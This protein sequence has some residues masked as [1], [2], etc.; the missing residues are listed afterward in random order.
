MNEGAAGRIDNTRR[1]GHYGFWDPFKAWRS[2][3]WTRWKDRIHG[4]DV[5]GADRR[6][7]TNGGSC[8]IERRG[9]VTTTR[10]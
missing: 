1:R 3:T 7:R 9:R 2:P 4:P 8:N 10:T 5:P 6:F